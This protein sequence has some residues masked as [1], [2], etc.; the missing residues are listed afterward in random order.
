MFF[1]TNIYPSI[2]PSNKYQLNIEAYK[3]LNLKAFLDKHCFCSKKWTFQL[4][5]IVS[6]HSISNRNSE[7]CLLYLKMHTHLIFWPL[8]EFLL[9][10]RVFSLWQGLYSVWY[11]VIAFWSIRGHSH[12]M[13]SC[14]WNR[15]SAMEWNRTQRVSRHAF[16]SWTV[17]ELHTVLLSLN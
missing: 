9:A 12:K 6:L 11:L 17:F 5:L 15:R 8:D 14:I 2:H 16:H 7:F 1:H 10:C 13:L 3:P 4:I